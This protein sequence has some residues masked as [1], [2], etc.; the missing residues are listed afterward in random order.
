MDFGQA[1]DDALNATH[2]IRN[3]VAALSASIMADSPDVVRSSALAFEGRIEEA[4]PIFDRLLIILRDAKH[5]T[6]ESAYQALVADPGRQA[7]AE[8][9][10]ILIREYQQIRAI[11]AMSDRRINDALLGL[12]KSPWSAA[13]EPASSASTLHAKA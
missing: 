1:L 12:S 10:R 4:R 3:Q 7:E 13:N 6:L 11:I 9:M 5:H 8:R 2:A